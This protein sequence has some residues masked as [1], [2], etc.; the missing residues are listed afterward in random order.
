LA[1]LHYKKY[2]KSEG[3]TDKPIIFHPLSDWKDT[4]AL[5]KLK[6][7][8]SKLLI[9]HGSFEDEY[10]EQLISV[11]YLT[12]NEKVLEIGANIGRNTLIIS[13]LL[14]DDSNLLTLECDTDIFNK[15]IENKAL[16]HFNFNTENAALSSRK[17]I[18]KDWDT[19]PSE[20]ILDGYFPVNTITLLELKKK[21]PIYFDTLI[22]DCEGAFYYILMDT[23]EILNGIK[24]IIM[25]NDYHIIEHKKYIDSILKNNNFYVEFTYSGGWGPCFDNFYEVWKKK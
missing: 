3:R 9:N 25:E 5:T 17:L 24:L 22:L 4:L 6:D 15:L 11:K 16:N 12:G 8:H 19:I 13:Y 14:N 7:I 23:P 1:I 20:E 18:Q 2:G 21:Y 10:P